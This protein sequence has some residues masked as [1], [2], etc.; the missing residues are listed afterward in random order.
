MNALQRD[1]IR[2]YMKREFRIDGERHH[3]C[4]LGENSGCQVKETFQMTGQGQM[5]SKSRFIIGIQ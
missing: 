2:K 4:F 1:E 3:S 5:G